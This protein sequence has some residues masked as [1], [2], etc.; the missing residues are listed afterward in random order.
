MLFRGELLA[1]SLS[2]EII[3]PT[4]DK[5]L[6]LGMFSDL[7]FEQVRQSAVTTRKVNKPTLGDVRLTIPHLGDGDVSDVC[8]GV[9]QCNLPKQR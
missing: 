9:L 1:D 7:D 3:P 2:E 4:R 6:F 5:E 8:C